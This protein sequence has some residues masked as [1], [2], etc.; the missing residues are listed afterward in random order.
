MNTSWICVISLDFQQDYLVLFS[1][2][3]WVLSLVTVVTNAILIV[4][5]YKT[6]QLKNASIKL[7]AIMSL[8]DLSSGI[9]AFPVVA[10]AFITKGSS[11]SCYLVHAGHYL[12][13]TFV[14]FSFFLVILVAGDRYTHF[15]RLPHLQNSRN[16]FPLFLLVIG[17]FVVANAFA[18]SFQFRRSFCLQLTLS[19]FNLCFSV[20]IYMLYS[21]ALKNVAVVP[22]QQN[23]AD[24][25]GNR[26]RKE[27]P[28]VH[29]NTVKLI[30]AIVIVLSM[31]YHII[32]TIWSYYV[33]KKQ[34]RPGIYL[35]IAKQISHICIFA[36]MSANAILFCRLN[37]RCWNYIRRVFVRG[38]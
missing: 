27:K 31:P 24:E 2:M 6:H 10:I 14:I 36:N 18:I 15:K 30:V 9:L 28:R 21:L 7:I 5:L 35:N 11:I 33:F 19:G 29:A 12:T 37:S 8:S 3:Y 25:T 23:S 20:A 13:F 26:S 38:E 16:N 22:T 1:T 17:S 4:A 34:V 32:S